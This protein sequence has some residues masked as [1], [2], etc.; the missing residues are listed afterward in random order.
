MMKERRVVVKRGVSLKDASVDLA[1][2]ILVI[3]DNGSDVFLLS[4]ALNKQNLRFELMHLP[5]AEPPS[6]SSAGRAPTW[7]APFPILS[8]W[9]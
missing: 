9:T 6:R 1:V 2:R 7:K 5:M 4:R 8:C 3:E